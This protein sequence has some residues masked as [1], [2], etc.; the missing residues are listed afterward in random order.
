MFLNV[1]NSWN[2]IMTKTREPAGL[3]VGYWTLTHSER[4]GSDVHSDL[5]VDLSTYRLKPLPLPKI[6]LWEHEVCKATSWFRAHIK[7]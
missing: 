2:T 4:S 6:K 1:V 5:R 7:L 3:E